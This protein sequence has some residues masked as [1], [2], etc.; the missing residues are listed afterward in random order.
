MS[1][2]FRE[3]KWMWKVALCCTAVSVMFV[4]SK[5]VSVLGC[6]KILSLSRYHLYFFLTGVTSF[7]SVL[8]VSIAFHCMK[9]IPF[10]LLSSSYFWGSVLTLVSVWHSI[11]PRDRHPRYLSPEQ[12][13]HAN[14]FSSLTKICKFPLGFFQSSPLKS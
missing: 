7:Q 13:H 2:V 1:T 6:V 4:L 8:S 11:F 5:G 14:R 9:E 10:F 12:H 3:R